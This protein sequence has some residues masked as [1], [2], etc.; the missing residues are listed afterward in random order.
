MKHRGLYNKQQKMFFPVAFLWQQWE[1]SYMT[2]DWLC[3][4]TR[5][6][7]RCR[8]SIALQYKCIGKLL[9]LLQQRYAFCFFLRTGLQ[10][11]CHS[12]VLWMCCI[13][14]EKAHVNQTDVVPPFNCPDI[15]VIHCN[16]SP[17]QWGQFMGYQINRNLLV[18]NLLLAI[19]VKLLLPS[20]IKPLKK[21]TFLKD[22]ES[23]YC[24]HVV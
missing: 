21:N 17:W 20:N 8:F 11:C 10:Q 18:C 22:K 13:F 24:G 12:L 1:R 4:I 3:D 7:S 2:F 6:E 16:W 19:A 15:S 23:A 9:Q 14:P 5:K